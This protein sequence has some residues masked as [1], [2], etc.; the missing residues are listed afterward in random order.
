DS[1]DLL[2]VFKGEKYNKPLR[3]ATV[4]NTSPKKFALRQADWVLIDAPTGAAR[5]EK[6]TYLNHFGLVP[7]GQGHEGLLFNLKKDPRQSENL[8]NK[9]PDR[10]QKM[11]ALLQEYLNGKPCAPRKN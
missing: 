3:V 8:Y 11:K 10:V 6:S 4:Q 7:Y 2:P 1:Y 5:K 9:Y